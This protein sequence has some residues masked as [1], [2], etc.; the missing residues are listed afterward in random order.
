MNPDRGRVRVFGTISWPIGLTGCVHPELTGA[1]N[2]KFIARIYGVDTEERYVAFLNGGHDPYNG[3]GRGVA[4]LDAWTG[5]PLFKASYVEGDTTTP[6]GQMRYGFPATI[7]L[8]VS[9]VFIAPMKPSFE[10]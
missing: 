6:A 2:V 3:R 10:S 9:K 8:V 5:S 4:M 1:Q 7:G